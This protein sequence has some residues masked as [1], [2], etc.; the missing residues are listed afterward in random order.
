MKGFYNHYLLDNSPYM[1]NFQTKPEFA[2][3]NLGLYPMVSNGNQ[4]I[5]GE[6]YEIDKPTE[7]TLDMLEGIDVGLYRK[8]YIDVPN[9]GD[10]VLIYVGNQ[11]SEEDI[12]SLPKIISGSYSEHT[13][14]HG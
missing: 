8:E 11:W 14:K 10:N 2:L 5:K 6:I 13:S 9:F 1:G 3:Y 12:K 4:S 7:N